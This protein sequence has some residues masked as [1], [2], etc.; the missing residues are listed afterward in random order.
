[1]ARAVGHRVVETF[2]SLVP[3][4]VKGTAAYSGVALRD[5]EGTVLVDGRVG[6]RRFRGDVLFTHFGLSGPIILQLSRAAAD[7]LRQHLPVEISLNLAPDL[8]AK[9]LDEALLGRL[10]ESPRATVATIFHD[11]MPRSVV[12][13][14][15]AAAGIDGSKR[16]S[17]VSRGERQR[18]VE[19][20]RAWRFPV[21]GWHS[22]DAAEVTAGGVDVKEVDPRTFGS[23]LVPGL[24]WAGEV[25]D[26]DGYVGGYNLQAA[27]STGWVAGC[28][29]AKYV[30]RD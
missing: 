6:D 13:A 14:F 27:W 12:P 22:M 11:A 23:R 19:T 2:P 29:A 10:Q 24:Y 7:G 1:M 30:A 8:S 5:V 20:Q 15:L 18:L 4:R 3:L 9:A 28:S 26:V 21:T 25:L 16:T 17:E